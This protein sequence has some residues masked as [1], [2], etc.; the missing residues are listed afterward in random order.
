MILRACYAISSTDLAHAATCL[1]AAYAMPCPERA[2]DAISLPCY[3]MSGTDPVCAG[4]IR[5]CV[6]LRSAMVLPGGVD[7][8][9]SEDDFHQA[10]GTVY[11]SVH[12]EMQYKKPRFQYNLYQE[13]GFLHLISYCNSTCAY[14]WHVLAQSCYQPT[15]VLC[16]VRYSHTYMLLPVIAQLANSGYCPPR[17]V[18]RLCYAISGTNLGYAASYCPSLILRAWGI[19]ATYYS[20]S[21]FTT[22]SRTRGG[23]CGTDLAYGAATTRLVSRIEV[24]AA[25]ASAVAFASTCTAS[26]SDFAVRFTGL[27]DPPGQQLYTFS[28]ELGGS[29]ERVRVWVSLLPP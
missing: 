19:M 9:G 28:S 1:R 27:I 13:C 26:V 3:A 8:A 10:D 21:D 14:L 20:S 6:V 29:E 23:T 4:T 24:P 11:P 16:D 15:R 22:P 7:A 18:L 17:I 25:D 12:P 2:Y 5:R